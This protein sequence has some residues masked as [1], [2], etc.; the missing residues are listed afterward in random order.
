MTQN[1]WYPTN[2]VN[3]ARKIL[4]SWIPVLVLLAS[5]PQIAS[6]R[7]APDLDQQF[8]SAVAEYEVGKF[9]EASARLEKLLPSAPEN[10][11]LHELLGLSYAAQSK[12]VLA[13]AHLEKAV[14]LQPNSVSARSNLAAN[15]ISLGKLDLARQQ[16]QKA[17]EL[18]PENFDTNHNL[19]EAYVRAGKL[20]DA[21][22]SLEKAQ[23]IDPSSYDNGYDLALAYLLTRRLGDARQ[24][25][26]KLIERQ[27]TAELHNLL[28]EVEEKDGKFIVAE[29]E[30]ERAAHA[31]PSESHLFDWGSELLI[32]RTLDPAIE[33]FQKGVERYPNS[34]RLAIGLGMALYSLGKYDEAVKSLL[35]AADINPADPRCYPFLSK[36]YDSSPS[37][38]DEVI[39]R[40]RRFSELQPRNAL[41]RYYYAMSLWKGKRAQDPDLDLSRIEVLLKKSIALDPKLAEAHLQLGNLYSEQKKYGNSILEYRHALELNSDLADAHYRLGQALVRTGD[42][43]HARAELETYQK[44]RAQHLADLDQ[45]KAEIRQFVYSAKDSP[46]GKQ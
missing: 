41:A 20:P 1:R 3:Q 30:F 29:Q 22:P 33:V 32:H 27:D 13:N 19:G 6:A 2:I 24:L 21:I 23:Q 40:F 5:T 25:L 4:C 39:Q 10:F 46:G 36:A 15:L 18:E 14:R 31:D 26:H 16:F 44:L 11:D 45:Q 43:E 38:A 17:A 8:K 37:Q 28:G 35:R 42:K 9:P 7:Q 12:S 34:P